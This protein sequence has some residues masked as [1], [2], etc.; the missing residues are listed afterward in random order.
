MRVRELFTC[1]K[2]ISTP[3]VRHK[4]WQHLI[5]CAKHEFKIV[6][7]PFLYFFM[8]FPF[9]YFLF[10]WGR[11]ERGPCSYVSSGAMRNSDLHNFKSESLCVKL[12]LYIF[13]KVDF[14]YEQN[15]FKALDLETTSSDVWWK[16]E[17]IVK[18]LDLETISSD[19]W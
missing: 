3:H 5:E 11:Q 16:V 17:R 9:L 6:Y 10:F 13:W 19:I 12:F 18:A 2:G 15:S 14:N 1:G 4:G 7:F 8:Y